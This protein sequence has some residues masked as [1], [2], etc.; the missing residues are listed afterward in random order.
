MARTAKKPII[1]PQSVTV[2]FESGVLVVRGPKGEVRRQMPR[3]ISP[4]IESE[5]HTVT[6]AITQETKES[7]TLLGTVNALA[8]SMVRG[9]SEG[10][11]KILELEGVGYR[12]AMDGADLL[13]S[14]GFSHPVKFVLPKDIA[15]KLEKNNIEISGADKETVGQVAA[16][17]RDLKKPEPYKGKGIHY[18]GEHIRR[19]AGKKAGAGS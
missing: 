13:L 2:S 7:N 11:V 3:E 5:A 15:V 1:F 18:R 8:L 9:A 16:K 12:V 14:L 4:V 10:F 17:I 6:F 19:K